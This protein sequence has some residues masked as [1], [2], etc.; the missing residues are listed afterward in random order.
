M[1][2]YIPLNIIREELSK[3]YEK[4]GKC[5]TLPAVC[6][7]LLRQPDL[8]TDEYY[9]PFSYA[10]EQ[11]S[12]EEYIRLFL[13]SMYPIEKTINAID[14][15]DAFSY[16]AETLF[17]KNVLFFVFLHEN[18]AKQGMHRHDFFEIT[19]VFKGCCNIHLEN[20]NIMM[21][22]GNVCIVAPNTLHEPFVIDADSFVI[23]LSMTKAAFEA[24]FS[25]VLLRK[26]LIST[27]I[28]NILYKN[29][30]PDYLLIPSKNSDSIKN[31]IKHLSYESRNNR[32]YS[33]SFCICWLSVFMCSVLDNYQSNIHT[34]TD[35]TDQ[36]QADR[37]LL[38]EYIQRN[39]RTATL[40]SVSSFFNYNKSYLSRLILQITG[41]TFTEI[42]T[43]LK[44]EAG[45]ELL[46]NT[47]LSFDQIAD[48]VGYSSGDYFSK[49]FKKKYKMAASDYRKQHK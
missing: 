44:L 8:L 34:Y 5:T 2:K 6:Q 3:Y 33:Y 11:L 47:T 24:A 35:T 20:E 26:D 16:S 9:N 21:T 13:T 39:Y 36:L 15:Q 37:L 29:N 10:A 27:Y 42:I 7:K 22:E 40:E 30:I 49:T 23:N 41:R 38:I 32:Y 25:V 46:E 19:Y 1:P 31:A 48:L 14:H 43:D 45:T 4:H 18:F 12:D 28:K 17:S